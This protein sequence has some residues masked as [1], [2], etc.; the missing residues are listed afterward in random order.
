MILDEAQYLTPKILRN[1]KMLMNFEYDSMNCSTL[2]LSVEPYFNKALEKPV[3]EALRQQIV[4]HY[5]FAGL[6]PNELNAYV[7]HKIKFAGGTQI[8]HRCRCAY[9]TEWLLRWKHQNG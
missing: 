1:L 7:T 6:D 2:I 9:H 8:H 5:N 3:N 4:V